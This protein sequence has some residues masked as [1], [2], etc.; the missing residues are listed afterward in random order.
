MRDWSPFKGMIQERQD[1]ICVMLYRYIPRVVPVLIFKMRGS[2]T[3]YQGNR[4][5]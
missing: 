2:V 1:F 4:Q 5:W 3:F